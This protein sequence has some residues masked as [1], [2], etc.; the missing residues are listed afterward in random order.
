M[1]VPWES[2]P[3]PFALLTQ[4]STTEPH[5]HC[6]CSS[7]EHCWCSSHEHCWCSSHEHCWCSSHEH[8]W[9]SS[10]EHCWCS[11]H[12]HCWCSSHEHC[13]CSANKNNM[14]IPKHLQ[15]E[16]FSE[17]SVVFS[18]RIARVPIFLAMTVC[19]IRLRWLI[20][21]AYFI[22][23]LHCAFLHYCKSVFE[24]S[25]GC[26]NLKERR[27]SGLV[28]CENPDSLYRTLFVSL[29]VICILVLLI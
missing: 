22:N 14:W 4:R 5:E 6:W 8:C 29:P 23:A 19:I 12:E 9:C 2:N 27:A 24:G 3:Q 15:L 11:S 17:R 16:Q 7:H 28:F 21:S 20:Y 1:C 25:F 13:W 10:H 18:D 26:G